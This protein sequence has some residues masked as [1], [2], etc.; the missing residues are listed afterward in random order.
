MRQ[1]NECFEWVLIY[2]YELHAISVRIV[3]GNK[4]RT[5]MEQIV[6]RERSPMKASV[7]PLSN[8]ILRDGGV[9]VHV[10]KFVL[11]ANTV[12]YATVGRVM[13]NTF[14]HFPYEDKEFA[15]S[16]AWGYGVIVAS[17]SP[18]VPVGAR[19]HGY[20]PMRGYTV[21]T[22]TKVKRGQFEDSAPHR[23]QLIPAYRT[24]RVGA[25]YSVE[26]EDQEDLLNADGLLF[27]TGWGCAIQGKLKGAESVLFTSAS[28]RTSL[29]AA[30]SAKFGKMC[31]CIIGVTSRR[32]LHFVRGT[33]LYDVVVSYEDIFTIDKRGVGSIAIYD[34]A[35]NASA[36]MAIR[37]HFG[38]Q[39]LDWGK[40]GQ[41]HVSVK[42]SFPTTPK[43]GMAKFGGAPVEGFLVFIAL[44]NASKELGAT[45]VQ[46]ML[47]EAQAKYV[48]WKLP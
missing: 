21:L 16:P 39:I 10:C 12:T 17:R 18:F 14:E 13:L 34:M 25:P 28:S 22:P 36:N 3:E 45:A 2:P 48:S 5:I 29:C 27:S 19:I 15:S 47:S 40:V 11:T 38:G 20:F 23:Q 43:D 7:K 33:G 41:T 31:K 37:Q 44:A 26:N 4:K 1:E 30:F 32:N 42:H 6:V 35:G 8:I 9:L 24:Y 46:K